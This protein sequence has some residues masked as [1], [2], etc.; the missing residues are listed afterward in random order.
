MKHNK[1]N[2]KSNSHLGEREDRVAKVVPIEDETGGSDERSESDDANRGDARRNLQQHDVGVRDAKEQRPQQLRC[3]EE[4]L[5]RRVNEEEC[6]RAAAGEGVRDEM[7]HRDSRGALHFRNARLAARPDEPDARAAPV[8]GDA[9]VLHAW[10]AAD[11]AEHN[12]GDALRAALR[13]TAAARA[14]A[15]VAVAP[16]RNNRNRCPAQRRARRGGEE[17]REQRGV[18]LP[19]SDA[20]RRCR[21]ERESQR[22]AH[23]RK[24]GVLLGAEPEERRDALPRHGAGRRQRCCC[25]RRREGEEQRERRE[26]SARP[27]RREAR[28][29][30][31]QRIERNGEAERNAT[32][33]IERGIVRR[34]RQHVCGKEQRN[35]CP[36]PTAVQRDGTDEHHEMNCHHHIFIRI[37]FLMMTGKG[38]LDSLATGLWTTRS[39]CVPAQACTPAF[40]FPTA[41]GAHHSRRRRKAKTPP[42]AWSGPPPGLAAGRNGGGSG[43]PGNGSYGYNHDGGRGHNYGMQ[44]H[45]H[46]RGAGGAGYGGGGG[47]NPYAL[48]RA[49]H[50]QGYGQRPIPYATPVHG[51]AVFNQAMGN[52]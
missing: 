36:I 13:R 19:S 42:H 1:I 29:P 17:E 30:K 25:L 24:I 15:R 33:C 22:T 35:D 31:S 45:A 14:V 10:A 11:V 23:A 52:V 43:H 3:L 38:A 32:D 7:A 47:G 27:R 51:H 37:F 9:V 49:G 50:G 40:L 28:R 18:V 12:D 20:A 34:K 16:H 6:A 44:G 46:Y 2:N 39:W 21:Q 26:L 41:M 48:N 5:E 8:E 4:H